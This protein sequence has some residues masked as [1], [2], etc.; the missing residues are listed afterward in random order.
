MHLCIYRFISVILL[1]CI[2]NGTFVPG[3]HLLNGF[4]YIKYKYDLRWDIF[5]LGTKA[6]FTSVNSTYLKIISSELTSM[7][8]VGYRLICILSKYTENKFCYSW[9]IFMLQL[10]YWRFWWYW[11]IN[12]FP[13]PLFTFLDSLLHSCSCWS[14]KQLLSVR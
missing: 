3:I 2:L 6:L 9:T 5:V 12:I 10:P 14:Y 1:D 8:I 4:F 7:E 11:A 13:I